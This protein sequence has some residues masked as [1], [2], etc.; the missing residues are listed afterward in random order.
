MLL[1]TL[2]SGGAESFHVLPP[3]FYFL[4]LFYTVLDSSLSFSPTH[5]SLLPC[6]NFLL[7]PRLSHPLC[8]SLL[9]LISIIYSFPPRV[10]FSSPFQPPTFMQ[11]SPISS[12]P[13][14]LS[15][16]PSWI[17]VGE[18]FLF[19]AGRGAIEC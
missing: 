11:I 9:P 16:F 18:R 4:Y 10:F 1:T 3:N 7:N 14:F 5:P 6:F 13:S 8:S 17:L 2:K 12:S 19:L 15:L